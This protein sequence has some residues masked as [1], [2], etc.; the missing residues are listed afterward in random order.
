MYLK[1]KIHKTLTLTQIKTHLLTW[2]A[3]VLVTDMSGLALAVAVIAVLMQGGAWR[4]V[5]AFHLE[6]R[7]WSDM[8]QLYEQ[9]ISSQQRA[10]PNV[11][12]KDY[13]TVRS[14]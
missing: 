10:G 12:E 2:K 5:V 14:K 13:S 3:V 11:R 4:Q 9:K 6:S 1:K 7:I 8:N